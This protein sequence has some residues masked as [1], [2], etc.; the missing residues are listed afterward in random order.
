MLDLLGPVKYYVQVQGPRAPA[1]T[2]NQVT[3]CT[4]AC[5]GSEAWGTA[6]RLGQAP[7]HE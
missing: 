3:P 6:A 7:V 2:T 5:M 1:R 4:P